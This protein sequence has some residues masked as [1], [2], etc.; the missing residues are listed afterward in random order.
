[1][2]VY[3]YTRISTD[4]QDKA[5]QYHRIN[6]F[7]AQN[8]IKIDQWL[9][10]TISSQK[11]DRKIYRLL[12]N[13]KQN[14]LVIVSELSRLGRS[15]VTEIFKILGVIQEKGASLYVI[16]DSIKI[17]GGK[18]SVQAETLVFALGI[19]SRLERELISERTRAGLKRAKEEGKKLGRPSS[20]SIL[21]GREGEIEKY[22][23]MGLNKTSISILMGIS[24]STVYAYLKKKGLA[25]KTAKA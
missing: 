4:K 11:K 8:G 1:M 2:A 5:S 24:R 6:E 13:L 7:A 16:Q 12:D 23:S 15:S 3:G 17:N 18:M 19:A 25:T 9:D 21:N 14:D 10:E 22:L 20:Y